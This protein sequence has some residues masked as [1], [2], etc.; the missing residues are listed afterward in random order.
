MK[1]KLRFC[2]DH[3]LVASWCCILDDYLC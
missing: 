1:I 3:A 2:G